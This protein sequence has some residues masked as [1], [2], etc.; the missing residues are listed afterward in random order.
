MRILLTCLLLLLLSFK[1]YSIN[2]NQYCQYKAAQQDCSAEFMT[3]LLDAVNTKEDLNFLSGEKYQITRVDTQGLDLEGVSIIGDKDNK[4]V[5]HTDG[6]HLFDINSLL[7]ENVKIMGIHNEDNDDDVKQGN[8]LLLIGSRNRL[9]KINNITVRDVDFENAA[10][11]LLVFWNT[12]NVSVTNNTFSRSGLAMRTV[13]SADP[14]D[15]RPRGSGLLFHNVI[16]LE[17]SFNEFYQIKKVGVFLDGEDI[18]DEN[19]VIHDNYFDLLSEEKPTQRYGLKGGAGIYIANS[20]NTQ[21]VQIYNNNI[22]N[23]TMN[24]MRINGVNIKVFDN[25]FNFRGQCNE[26]DTS[27]AKPLVGMAIKAHFLL[28]SEITNNCIQ[29][30]HSGIVLESWD[31]IEGIKVNNNTIYGAKVNFWVDDQEG[32]KSSNIVIEDNVLANSS[33]EIESSGG[34]FNIVMLLFLYNV[35]LLRR[36]YRHLNS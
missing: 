18:L 1:V 15:L 9:I 14:N 10:E 17:V 19:I 35:A 6:L 21:N 34:S 4:A 8:S 28:D 24:G 22:L 27:I 11:D 23:Y 2:F 31:N 33:G 25:S 20:I 3:A 32:G 26:M 36:R 12:K 5:I 13:P 30:S 29:N 16:D 7:I